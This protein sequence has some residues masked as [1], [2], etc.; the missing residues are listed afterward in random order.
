[1]ASLIE[2]ALADGGMEAAE[3]RKAQHLSVQPIREEKVTSDKST[4]R[5]KYHI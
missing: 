1:M 3:A 5:K 4:D 2:Q